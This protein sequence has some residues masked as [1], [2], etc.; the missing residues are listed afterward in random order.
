MI[1]LEDFLFKNVIIVDSNDKTHI[2]YV[3]FYESEYDSGYDEPS[4]GLIPNKNSKSG[5]EFR[6]SEIKS[7]KLI[8]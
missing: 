5:I 8:D 3:D 2:G 6:Q 4:I 7:I 1:D